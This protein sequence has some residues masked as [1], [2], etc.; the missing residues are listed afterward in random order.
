MGAEKVP[1]LPLPSPDERRKLRDQMG[2]SRKAAAAELGV[3][4]R[5]LLRWELG[6]TEPTAS[7]HRKYEEMLRQW[8][9]A[10]DKFL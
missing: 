1:L 5:T 4:V 10:V 2:V 9:D 7:H 3:S 6:D 8:K